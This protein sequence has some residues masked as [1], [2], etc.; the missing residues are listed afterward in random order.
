MNIERIK[1]DM[2]AI[3]AFN[4]TPGEGYTRFS[5]SQQDRQAREYLKAE[6][7]RLGL[8]TTVDGVGNIRA[9]LEGSDLPLPQSWWGHISIPFCTVGNST[10]F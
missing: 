10:G 2:E 5:Y 1:K 4:R 7:D 3:C 6:F 9:R 8:A